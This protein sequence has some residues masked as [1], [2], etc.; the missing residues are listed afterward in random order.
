MSRCSG[1]SKDVEQRKRLGLIGKPFC[2]RA[3]RFARHNKEIHVPDLLQSLLAH[4]AAA[5]ITY[6]GCINLR[7]FLLRQ[8]KRELPFTPNNPIRT[9]NPSDIEAWSMYGPQPHL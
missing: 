6:M 8:P 4:Q 5:Y 2:T 1:Q 7:S 3:G 9:S